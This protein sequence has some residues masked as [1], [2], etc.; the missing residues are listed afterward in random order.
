MTYRL[1]IDRWH[2]VRLNKL[3]N[4]H[5]CTRSRLRKADDNMVAGYT[6]LNRIPVA[7]GRR[8][9]DLHLTLGPRQQEGDE[10]N[11]WKSIKDALVNARMLIDDKKLW[12]EQGE[13]TFERG[14]ERGTLITLT[15]L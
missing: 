11:W 12:C 13:V 8:R 4:C 2:P 1:K 9:V 7:T 6:I 10:D 14:V 5:P 3:M 15:D